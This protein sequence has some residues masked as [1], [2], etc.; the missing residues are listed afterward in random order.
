[1]IVSMNKEQ[2][3]E[4]AMRGHS[5][6]SI[7][8]A[9]N[10]FAGSDIFAIENRLNNIEDI[11]WLRFNDTEYSGG[12]LGGMVESDAIKIVNFVLEYKDVDN[13]IVAN[14]SG[15]KRSNAIAL[16]IQESVDYTTDIN[17]SYRNEMNRLCYSFLKQSFDARYK[18]EN[19]KSLSSKNVD[20][21]PEYLRLSK[22][23]EEHIIN[24]DIKLG[25]SLPTIRDFAE[26]F[27]VSVLTAN[28]CYKRLVDLGL[29]EYSKEDDKY[30]VIYKSGVYEYSFNDAEIKEMDKL[31]SNVVRIAR[32]NKISID[33]I[34]Q[35]LKIMSK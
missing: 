9:V 5:E 10:S 24:E 16:A 34:I 1:M 29:I 11:L 26:T 31:L 13:I 21:E 17:E 15:I 18:R 22:E 32:K 4:Y 7:V 27:D 3:E 2:F 35:T 25:E 8:V 33:D 28:I 23:I 12:E 20:G 14:D 30:F 6:S 19:S